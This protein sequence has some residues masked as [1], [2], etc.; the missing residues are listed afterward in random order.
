MA[1]KLVLLE[2][3]QGLLL[4]LVAPTHTAN[5][6]YQQHWKAGNPNPQGRSVVLITIPVWDGQITVAAAA[7]VAARVVVGRV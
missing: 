4:T 5:Y 3:G 7:T 2:V 1:R 6:F